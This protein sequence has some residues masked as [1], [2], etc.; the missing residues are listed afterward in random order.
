MIICADHA[1]WQ[2]DGYHPIA[3][4]LGAERDPI[5][6]FKFLEGIPKDPLC[7]AF[8]YL[9]SRIALNF[10]RR[11]SLKKQEEDSGQEVK[12]WEKDFSLAQLDSRGLF[13]EYLEMGEYTFDCSILILFYVYFY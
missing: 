5:P 1:K 12:Q 11:R 6:C 7:H 3:L 2:Q 4:T 8:I 10:W 13:S 9:F